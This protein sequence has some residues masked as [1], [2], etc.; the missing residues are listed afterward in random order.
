VPSPSVVDQSR[1]IFSVLPE[2]LSVEPHAPSIYRRL[3]ELDLDDDAALVRPSCIVDEAGQDLGALA[4]DM[5][6]D[7]DSRDATE[8]TLNGDDLRTEAGRADR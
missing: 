8:I 4:D 6:V 5:F 3:V 1:G 7:T 2:C